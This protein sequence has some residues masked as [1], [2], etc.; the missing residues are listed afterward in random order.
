MPDP[1]W[2][3]KQEAMQQAEDARF[4]S[5]YKQTTFDVVGTWILLII[6]FWWIPATFICSI[7]S[8][9]NQKKQKPDL[10]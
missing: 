5:D 3:M 4:P 2:E 6:F 8:K 1:M 9:L 7:R 10:S